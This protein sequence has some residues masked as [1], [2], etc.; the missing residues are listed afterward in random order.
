MFDWLRSIFRFDGDERQQFFALV[1]AL[2]AETSGG[3]PVVTQRL[4]GN[5]ALRSGTL[6]LGDPQGMPSLEIP[7]IAASQVAIRKLCR[8][9]SSVLMKTEPSR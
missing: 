7:N 1:D 8:L 6:A 2:N 4:L 5:L 3:K 9:S